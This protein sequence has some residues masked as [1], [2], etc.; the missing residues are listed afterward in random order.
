MSY[1]VDAVCECIVETGLYADMLSNLAWDALTAEALNDPR[2]GSK[3]DFVEAH[4]ATLH[5]VVRKT[6]SA[7]SAFRQHHA[8]DVVQKFR[9]CSEFPVN[10]P[11]IFSSKPVAKRR[12]QYLVPIQRNA[13]NAGKQAPFSVF[14]LWLVSRLRRLRKCKNCTQGHALRALR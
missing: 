14:A 13:R 9:Q 7:R 6:E 8:L 3:R 12:S 10:F 5:N 11:S 2:S 1:N 4:I